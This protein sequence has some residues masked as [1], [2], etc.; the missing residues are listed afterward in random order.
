MNTNYLFSHLAYR[1]ASYVEDTRSSDSLLDE[2]DF[3]I[4]D[5][6][7][8]LCRF[9]KRTV[10]HFYIFRCIQLYYERDFRKNP[11]DYFGDGFKDSNEPEE[12]EIW[13]DS[14]G[15]SRTKFSVFAKDNVD[16]YDGYDYHDLLW[17]WYLDQ[18]DSFIALW[19]SITEEVFYLLFQNRR[20][21]LNF[22]L[23]LSEYLRENMALIPA[24]LLTRSGKFPRVQIPSWVK[25]AVYFRDRGRCLN[26][27]SDLS[28]LLC[29]DR[30]QHY[31]HIVPLDRMG[32]NDPTNIQLLCAQCNERKSSTS[33]YTSS[34]Y[35]AWW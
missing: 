9:T 16:S 7:Q 1:I 19:Q 24:Q 34:S 11:E 2:L 35:P 32:V 25:K 31:D 26:C 15:I 13:L 4:P 21:L 18:E 6:Q 17:E 8:A 29:T 12:I 33:I 3:S 14:Y 20:F 27:N 10:L 23:V 22:N 28:Y 30:R 5:L